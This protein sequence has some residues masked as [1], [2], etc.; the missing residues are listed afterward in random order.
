MPV[1]QVGQVV[2]HRGDLAPVERLGRH[3]HRGA[4]AQQPFA[5][6]VGPEGGE[7]RA[8][9]RAGLEGAEADD[10][11]LVLAPQERDESV[12]AGD[13]ELAEQ[14]GEPVGL[15]SQVRVG[16]P[17]RRAVG[18]DAAQGDDL[19][20]PL[21]DVPVD[22]LVGDVERSPAGQWRQV[23]ADPVP[24]RR[25]QQ[26]GVVGGPRLSGRQL[27][28]CGVVHR[29]TSFA[30][31]HPRCEVEHAGRGE[32]PRGP[33]DGPSAAVGQPCG[34]MRILACSSALPSA[35]KA[36]ATPSS[37]TT[38]VMSG[39]GSTVPSATRCRVSRNST[40]S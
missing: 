17:G 40:G 7:Q 10:V 20:P 24:A 29:P 39:R 33:R 32:G 28:A 38:S 31:S 12:A 1:P 5:D 22:G 35:S 4:T 14:V 6:R 26:R 34:S 8:E 11:L 16:H 30:S 3:E 27:S 15:A 21:V 25:A 13:A 2:S 37:P 36:A 18:R 9:H 19:A 23:L